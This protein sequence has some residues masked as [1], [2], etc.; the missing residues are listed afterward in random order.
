MNCLMNYGVALNEVCIVTNASS[1]KDKTRKYSTSTMSMST[2]WLVV[3]RHASD[4]GGGIYHMALFPQDR[5]AV[6][7]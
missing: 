2:A 7:M 6:Y 3:C 1:K 5:S 4:G